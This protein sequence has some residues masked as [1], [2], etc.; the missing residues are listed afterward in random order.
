MTHCAPP[1]PTPKSFC[2]AGRMTF[3]TVP[4][5]NAML[6]AT[7][8]AA[9]IQG[10]LF[11]AQGAVQGADRMT[12]WSHG[13]F[14][15][16]T[17]AHSPC[18]EKRAGS[19]TRAFLLGMLGVIAGGDRVLRAC[20]GDIILEARLRGARQRR[21]VGDE[22]LVLLVGDDEMLDVVLA[23]ETA[24]PRFVGVVFHDLE[25]VAHILRFHRLVRDTVL[26]GAA[27]AG[28]ERLI[29]ERLLQGLETAFEFLQR[30]FFPDRQE[31]R[32]QRH[33]YRHAIGGLLEVD[34]AAVAIEGGVELVH[35]RKR[36][37]DACM[38]IFRVFQ[39]FRV[40]ARIFLVF[41]GPALLLEA[42]D[43]NGVDLLAQDDAVIDFRTGKQRL[44]VRLVGRDIERVDR[45]AFGRLRDKLATIFFAQAAMH[46][47]GELHA[48]RGH[49]VDDRAEAGERV[50]E[51]VNG[52]A[53]AQVSGDRDLQALQLFVLA[54]Q[55]EEIAERLCRVLVRAVA[56]VDDRD[57]RVF[58]GKPRRTVARMADDDDVGVVR[59]DADG[60]GETLALG[61]GTGRGI[62]ACNYVAAE[63]QH[64]AFERKAGARARLAQEGREDR[65]RGDVGAP[66][67]AVGEVRIGELVEIGLRH[68]ED[69][70]DLLVAEV[71]DRYDVAKN[72][73]RFGRHDTAPAGVA[74]R[75]A[76]LGYAFIL[77]TV[78]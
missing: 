60:V 28:G 44:L 42:G 57:R 70:L 9:R 69:R 66:A 65:F 58:G 77:K 7:T 19:R 1:M 43:I 68:V 3:A 53:A 41:V 21:R 45:A 10:A 11:F 76:S 20:E 12:P 31:K 24:Q 23:I 56:A 67:D 13:D 54:L 48:G 51:G 29:V 73:S 34:R 72:G 22:P 35:A 36:M 49:R 18:Q 52:A 46:V 15:I 71:V 26:V 27:D 61:G 25:L 16:A 39:E 78:A 2:S 5:M 33:A 38:G 8:V 63:T 17:T 37:H 50:D 75:R 32:N 47:R 40:D 6:E 64:R 30:F 62:R 14:R 4:S 59:D 55:R 74:R